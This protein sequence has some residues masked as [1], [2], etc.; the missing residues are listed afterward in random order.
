[1]VMVKLG[2]RFDMR[3]PDFG[4]DRPRLYQ[5]ML[6]ICAWADEIGFAS[7]RIS[8]H[9]GVEDGYLPAPLIAAAAIAARTQR[10]R[11]SIAAIPLPFH[12][13]VLVAEQIAILDHISEGR[14]DLTLAAGYVPSE[15]RMFGVSPSERAKR[16]E[17]GIALLR[18][19][20]TAERFSHAG[21]DIRVTPRPLQQP[22]PPLFIGGSVPAAAKRAARLDV[23]FDTH[24]P[25]L[26][27]IYREA[28]LAHGHTPSPWVQCG[29]TFLHVTE[30]PDAAWARIAPHAI[31]ETNAYGQWAV[32]T[33]LDSSYRPVGSADA[34]RA[35]GAY[36]V[37]TPEQTIALGSELGDEGML[38]FH[39]LLAGLDPDF[40]W[41]SLHLLERAVLPKLRAR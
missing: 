40:S 30:D 36:A 22:H 26:Y 13:P 28:A 27:A 5:E 39:P 4:A 7:V 3:A 29:P 9:H 15:F 32:E 23:G 17:D 34:L 8:E 35:T 11:L 20:W 2:L 10:I 18:Q 25:D 21:R 19:C 41:Q 1:M 37:L 38:L 12:D 16:M 6:R 31:H 33:G 14:V 24:L